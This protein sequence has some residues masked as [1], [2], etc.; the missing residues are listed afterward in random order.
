MCYVFVCLVSSIGKSVERLGSRKSNL[1]CSKK[2]SFFFFLAEQSRNKQEIN[3]KKKFW[4]VLQF[5]KM[6]RIE[7]MEFWKIIPVFA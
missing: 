1:R 6:N 2:K 7:I 4:T 5:L 3:E